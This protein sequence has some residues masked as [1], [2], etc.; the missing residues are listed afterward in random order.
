MDAPYIGGPL[1]VTWIDAPYIGGPFW[2]TWM[3][4]PYIGDFEKR[5]NISLLRE[6]LMR[7]LRDT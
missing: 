6:I 3:D 5:E 1:W 4:A 2:V 7:N